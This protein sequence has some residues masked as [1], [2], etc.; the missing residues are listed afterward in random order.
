[1]SQQDAFDRI[2]SALHDA[3][4]DNTLWPGASALIDAAVGMTGS[5]LTIV[6]GHS[7]DDA[8]FLFGDMYCHGELAVFGAEYATTYFPHDERIPRLLHLPGRGIVHISEVYTE[9][10]LKTSPTYNEGLRRFD[11]CNGLNLRM[12]RP[13]STH[14]VWAFTDPLD[15]TG[16]R[17]EQVEFISQLLP[18]IRQFVQVRQALARA[19]ALHTSLTRLLDN[20]LIGVLSLDRQG[21]IVK[22]N[23]HTLDILRRG[24]GV[25]VR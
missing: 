10:E 20:A 6:R 19:E 5:H 23:A 13:D 2:V 8:E 16:W 4:L 15:P 7:R 22:A 12:D 11:A 24:D 9:Q 1:M 17:S 21:R 18:H 14:I 25:L 3:A